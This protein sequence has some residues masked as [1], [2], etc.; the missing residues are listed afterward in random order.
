MN[1][2]KVLIGSRFRA[3]IYKIKL[4]FTK[5]VLNLRYKLI[6]ELIGKMPVIVNCTIYDDVM[7]YNFGKT[8]TYRPCICAKNTVKNFEQMINAEI[9]RR[10][11]YVGDSLDCVKKDGVRAVTKRRGNSFALSIGGWS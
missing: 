8:R 10:K 1:S 2:E 7:E 9:M 3:F 11:V 6:L 5:L 4:D